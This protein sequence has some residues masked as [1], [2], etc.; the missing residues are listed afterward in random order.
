MD[1]ESSKWSLDAPNDLD[2]ANDLNTC[3]LEGFQ[4]LKQH[5]PN[6]S[7]NK[8]VFFENLSMLLPDEDPEIQS[9]D[10]V[11]VDVMWDRVIISITKE[12][13]LSIS[14]N[15]EFEYFDSCVD[16]L[17]LSYIKK[18]LKSL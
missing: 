12:D 15:G 4:N 11:F 10:G 16:P 8:E 9:A 7:S 13:A 14:A 3:I 5:F 2:D 17:C 1:L 18:A 6:I